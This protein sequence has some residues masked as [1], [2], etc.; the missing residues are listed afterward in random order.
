VIK[1]SKKREMEY[2]VNTKTKEQCWKDPTLPL[3]WGLDKSRKGETAYVWLATGD[4]TTVKPGSGEAMDRPV[5]GGNGAVVTVEVEEAGAAVG[6]AAAPEDSSSRDVRRSEMLAA[7]RE[8]MLA[9][10]LRRGVITQQEHDQLVESEKVFMEEQRQAEEEEEAAVEE[11]A[12]AEATEAGGLLASSQDT[13]ERE[14]MLA[15]KLRRGVITQQEYDQLVKSEKVFMEEQRARVGAGFDSTVGVTPLATGAAGKKGQRGGADSSRSRCGFCAALREGCH[16]CSCCPTGVRERWFAC[17]GAVVA[18]GMRVFKRVEAVISP[19]VDRAVAIYSSSPCLIA[20]VNALGRVL[21]LLDLMS[22]AL[23]VKS[24]ARHRTQV[25]VVF[26]SGVVLLLL[27]Y[28]VMWALLY[29]VFFKMY[30]DGD[31]QLIFL[32]YYAPSH[33]S[34]QAASAAATAAGDQAK[35]RYTAGGKRSKCSSF[36]ESLPRCVLEKQPGDTD[37]VGQRHWKYTRGSTLRACCGAA[38]ALPTREWAWQVTVFSVGYLLGG[39]LGLVFADVL[40]VTRYICSELHTLP[41]HLMYYERLRLMCESLFEDIPQCCFQFTLF[42]YLSTLKAS[43]FDEKILVMSA[44]CSFCSLLKV[45]HTHTTHAY[46]TRITPLSIF[47]ALSPA[48]SLSLT[49]S[50]S[51]ARARALSRSH[52]HTLSHTQL[53][54]SLT[55]ALSLTHS[56]RTFGACLTA[57]AYGR[58]RL[59]STAGRS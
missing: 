31:L 52:T 42:Y 39:L 20:I 57:L 46:D 24:L 41:H 40:L 23:V 35:A 59:S 1:R 53:T 11:Q 38:A 13:A 32:Q 37:T 25:P 30:M 43:R 4:R 44:L 21:M 3:G 58:S 48:L 19:H 56:L 47:L 18:S 49:L 7:P 2:Y 22:D 33:S 50:L 54:L 8:A 28:L 29:Q 12:Q 51:L 45:R 14:A 6:V 27:P 10:K 26:W 34:T 9:V 36:M 5:V 15:D 16:T 55:L 17:I